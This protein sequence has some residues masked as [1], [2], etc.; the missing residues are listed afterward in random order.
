M[1]T[2]L[3]LKLAVYNAQQFPVEGQPPVDTDSEAGL[4]PVRRPEAQAQGQPTSKPPKTGPLGPQDTRDSIDVIQMEG[5][6]KDQQKG[7]KDQQKELADARY[8]IKVKNRRIWELEVALQDI[9]DLV[10]ATTHQVGDKR[11]RG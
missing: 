3:S 11:T 8:E 2:P 4:D 7:Y 6:Y 10:N 5:R 1:T 9:K